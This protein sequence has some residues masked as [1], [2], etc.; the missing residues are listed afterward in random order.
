MDAVTTRVREQYERFPYPAGAPALRVAGDVRLLLSLG[1]LD[2]PRGGTLRALDAGCGRGVG[3]LGQ[4]TLQPDVQFLGID[5]SRAAL[6]D[7]SREAVRRGLSNVRFEEVDLMTLDGL[8]SPAGGFDAIFSSGV[9]HHL[10]D[11][12]AGL[13]NLASVLA[14]HGV[15]SLMVYG[16]RGREPLQRVVRALQRLAPRS[17][18][19]DERV[20]IARAL[21]AAFPSDPIGSGPWRDAARLPDAEI[22]DRYLNAHEENYDVAGLMQ[23]VESAG[24]RFL[25]WSQPGEWEADAPTLAPH[26]SKL[27]PLER[28]QVIEEVT[29][30][31]R[32][33]CVLGH[34]AN[35]PRPP[36]SRAGL[37]AA[38]LRVNPE[39]TFRIEKRNLA[40]LQRTERIGWRMRAEEPVDVPK[41][42]LAQALTLLVDQ[43]TPFAGS[44][45]VGALTERGIA[46]DVALSVVE[47]LVAREILY[48]PHDADL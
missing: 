38:A 33:E 25:R 48:R 30:R 23:L 12:A 35:E 39:V 6:S 42:A 34:V 37:A 16:A 31:P 14:P 21:L 45:L 20:N 1:A 2:R 47:E 40:G 8:E 13:R 3:V 22:V 7:A 24:L 15:I 5:L 43:T 18:P 29:W 26:W 4:A 17:L 32:L 44:D 41:G 46:V 11:P 9:I 19:L 10:S 36:L 28:W 27:S